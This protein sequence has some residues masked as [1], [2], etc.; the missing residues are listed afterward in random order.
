MVIPSMC[1]HLRLTVLLDS[2]WRDNELGL[3]MSSHFNCYGFD[4]A[5]V[6]WN[7]FQIPSW[8][9]T[10][11]WACV[12]PAARKSVWLGRGTDG[13][14][15]SCG[16]VRGRPGSVPAQHVREL[17]CP[18]RLLHCLRPQL[19]ADHRPVAGHSQNQVCVGREGQSFPGQEVKEQMVGRGK[20]SSKL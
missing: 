9:C 1:R 14:L 19:G 6:E 10:W 17:R 5:S 13:Q 12:L 4:A 15:S 20:G 3:Y 2:R 8:L 11:V 7:K 18:G 16:H